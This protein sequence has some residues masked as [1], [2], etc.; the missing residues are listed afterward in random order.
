MRKSKSTAYAQ[1]VEILEQSI[2][3]SGADADAFR[4][5]D[6]AKQERERARAPAPELIFFH[7][8]RSTQLRALADSLRTPT[9]GAPPAT[10]VRAAQSWFRSTRRRWTTTNDSTFA[11]RAELAP[12][13]FNVLGL[14]MDG[15][16]G[17]YSEDDVVVVGD[18]VRLLRRCAVG[19]R[20]RARAHPTLRHAEPASSICSRNCSAS[21]RRLRR[22]LCDRSFASWCEIDIDRLVFDR[23]TNGVTKKNNRRRSAAVTP[24]FIKWPLL[25]WYT[26]ARTHTETVRHR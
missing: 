16:G 1:A 14:A 3:R 24:P 6:Q 4:Q 25:C 5:C 26:R 8:L 23:E 2:L 18:G 15:V 7:S 20:F 13:Y 22:P 12:M 19:T 10:P 17:A 9:S 11:R 21:T